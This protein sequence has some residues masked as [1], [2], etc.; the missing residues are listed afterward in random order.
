MN[1][2]EF[3]TEVLKAREK[4]EKSNN[5]EYWYGFIKGLRRNYHGE[6]F[7]NQKIHLQLLQAGLDDREIGKG[8]LKGCIFG[9]MIEA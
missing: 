9:E 3:K 7:G 2:K 1:F 5:H 6:K 4:Q 8:Y